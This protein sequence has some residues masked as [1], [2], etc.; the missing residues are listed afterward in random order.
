[1]VSAGRSSNTAVRA[2][3]IM[4]KARTAGAAAPLITS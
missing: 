3:A 2:A 1:M 4:T